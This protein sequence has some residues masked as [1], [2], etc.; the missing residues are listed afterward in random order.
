MKITAAL[1]R[2]GLVKQA[3]WPY[4]IISHANNY[5]LDCP[6]LLTVTDHNP[7]LRIFNKLEL[8]TLLNLSI[9]RLKKKNVLLM[10]QIKH[11]LVNGIVDLMLALKT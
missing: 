2:F 11:F 1:S 4:S 7:L 8:N 3:A 10:Q 6:V 5:V 9:Y